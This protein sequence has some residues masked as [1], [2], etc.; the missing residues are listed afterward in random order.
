ILDG[1]VMEQGFDIKTL[2]AHTIESI[3]VLKEASA[4]YGD[5]GANGVILITTKAK[6]QKD[7]AKTDT[8][9]LGVVG[10]GKE[11]ALKE[12][13]TA[14]NAFNGALIV[15]DGEESTAAALRDLSPDDID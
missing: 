7:A 1:K 3:D 14:E 4:L 13:P 9:E 15:I 8:T 6:A 5:R 11:E 10:F 12:P 2:D